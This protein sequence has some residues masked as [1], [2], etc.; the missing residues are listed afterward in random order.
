MKWY[1]QHLSPRYMA[2]TLETIMKSLKK[3]ALDLASELEDIT[4]DWTSTPTGEEYNLLA[5]IISKDEYQHLTNLT[6]VKET[7]PRPY[8]PVI[9][10]TTP[11]YA[12]KRMEQEWEKK[13]KLGPSGKDSSTPLQLLHAAP[14]MRTGPH[15]LSTSTP[16]TEMCN[17]FKS[18]SI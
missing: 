14:W 5:E 12:R 13:N 15:N 11:T 18:W 3:V 4:Y 1:K 16:P 2:A 17:L 8:N 7:E 6:W 9:D 10:G